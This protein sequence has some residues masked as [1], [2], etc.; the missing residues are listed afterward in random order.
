MSLACSI[1][2]TEFIPYFC[3]ALYINNFLLT[4]L[5]S[6]KASNADGH[7]FIKVHNNNYCAVGRRQKVIFFQKLNYRQHML[8]NRLGSS[9]PAIVGI[10]CYINPNLI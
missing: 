1:F 9:I 7:N 2:L 10:R 6:L 5:F 4:S 3:R 8:P